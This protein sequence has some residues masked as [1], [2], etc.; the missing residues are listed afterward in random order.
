MYDR[1]FDK[2][3]S[4]RKLLDDLTKHPATTLTELRLDSMLL[5]V[6]S[7]P[8]FLRVLG[9]ARPGLRKV[10]LSLNKDLTIMSGMNPRW[11]EHRNLPSSDKDVEVWENTPK[12]CWDYIRKLKEVSMITT[13]NGEAQF[14]LSSLDQ[15][16]DLS[17]HPEALFSNK[18]LGE[19]SVLIVQGDDTNSLYQPSRVEPFQ[20]L[21]EELDYVPTFDWSRQINHTDDHY[22]GDPS[23]LH[24]VPEAAR[25]LTL[26][27]CRELF[28]EVKDAGI[29]VKLLLATENQKD[30]GSPWYTGSFFLPEWLVHF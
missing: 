5:S 23:C 27:H 9:K 8:Y 6:R 21:K 14:S 25:D 26:Q 20:W 22:D 30:E 29:P 11:G 15:H 12:T 28:N 18:D 2:P 24:Q 13:A 4:T 17:I 10:C 7:L 1:C 16:H 19:A 3:K